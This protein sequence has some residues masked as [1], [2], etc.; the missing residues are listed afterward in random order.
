[1]GNQLLYD[2]RIIV[3]K[4]GG[5][6][7]KKTALITGAS[8]GIGKACAIALYEA[9]Y[10]VIIHYCNS[11]SKAESLSKQLGNAMT[12][13]ADLVDKREIESMI[14]QV[15]EQY[16]GVDVLVNNAGIAQQK[17]FTDIAEA[18][19]DRMFDVNIKAI[20]HLCK[21][22]LPY[23]IQC[24]SGK[25][26]NISSMWG[27][28][29]GSCEVHYS[30]AKAAV[31]GFTKA[32]AKEVSLSNINVNC[33]APGVILTDM[34]KNFD[35]RTLNDLKEETPLNR[36]GTPE[37]IA[38]VVAFLVSEKASFLT[39]QVISVDGGMVI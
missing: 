19:W 7:M 3:R 14:Q 39:G 37:D 36:L 16:G 25:I 17:L 34:C 10:Q 26:V 33:V 8:R 30:A 20:F 1:M 12:I 23:M 13:K 9:G 11:K 24:Q 31:I 32:L 21:G 29:G 27:I 38:N 5:L 6:G 15:E 2:S 4:G 35:E 18:E 22:V 28:V